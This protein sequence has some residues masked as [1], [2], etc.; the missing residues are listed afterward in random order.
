MA[1]MNGER[2]YRQKEEQYL[3]EVSET[4]FG[5]FEVNCSGGIG[6]RNQVSSW[7]YGKCGLYLQ[8]KKMFFRNNFGL[9][10]HVGV[11]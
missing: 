4:P 7:K 9:Q 3:W 1:S 10:R 6:W 5:G 8:L 11:P 2:K